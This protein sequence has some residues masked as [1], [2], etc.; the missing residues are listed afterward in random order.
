MSVFEATYGL[1]TDRTTTGGA[2]TSIS[3]YIIDKNPV[4]AQCV[5]ASLSD[6]PGMR[7]QAAS[8]SPEGVPEDVVAGDGDRVLIFDPAHLSVSPEIFVEQAKSRSRS[9]FVSYSFDTSNEAVNAALDAGIDCIASKEES[10]AVLYLAIATASHGGRFLCPTTTRGFHRIHRDAV[11]EPQPDP[12]NRK[13]QLST[14]ELAV[15]TA[16]ARGLSQKQTA[17]ELSLSDKTVSTY[18]TRAMRKLGL[19]DRAAIV[20]FAVSQ[21]LIPNTSLL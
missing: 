13:A 18:K 14:R 16:L 2:D 1:N 12:Q 19:M 7:C 20:E 10:L 9:F 21:N 17:F 3:A 6:M 4:L 8:F 15:L 11:A 5:G